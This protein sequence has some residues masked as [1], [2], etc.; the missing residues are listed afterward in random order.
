MPKIAGCTKSPGI[1]RI[2]EACFAD[3]RLPLEAFEIKLG[4]NQIDA[5]VVAL[6]KMKAAIEAEPCAK[7]PS[8]LVVVCGLTSFAYTRPDG[9]MV[10]PITALRE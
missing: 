7:A 4:A 10:V 9:V 1:S 6:L 5:A 8:I 3:A 2:E